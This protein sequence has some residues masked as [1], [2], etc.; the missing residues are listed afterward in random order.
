MLLDHLD[1][2]AL[3]R[4]H[5]VEAARFLERVA[6]HRAEGLLLRLGRH[7]RRA[8]KHG[9]HKR[10][11]AVGIVPRVVQRAVD[12]RTAVVERREQEAE[13]RRADQPVD[14]AV[15][16]R[17]FRHAV[18]EHRLRLLDR[19]D[20]A[21]HV[22]VRFARGVVL[23]LA[24]PRAER[25]VVC[26]VREQNQVRA[27]RPV[28]GDDLLKERGNGR[29][30]V[31]GRVPQRHQQPVLVAV[32]DLRRGKRHVDEVLAQRARKRAPQHGEQVFALL[33]RQQ[34]ERLVERGDDLLP[35]VHIAAAHVRDVAFI[36]PEAPADLRNFLFV[37]RCF[38]FFRR[39]VFRSPRPVVP[40]RQ[41]PPK[42]QAGCRRVFHY[43]TCGCF[44]KGEISGGASAASP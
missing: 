35:L 11:V 8:A 21:Q 10:I 6:E 33:L 19:A 29:F 30:V 26:I 17:V 39:P 24:V 28:G 18:A 41:T 4:L 27:L 44:L 15:V 37:H 12:V 43:S 42:P 32:D 1:Q 23:P 20:A 34:R 7:R 22:A 14:P 36:R 3:H 16:E 9:V 31:Q 2:A 25:H 40:R 13:R 5:H 38:P